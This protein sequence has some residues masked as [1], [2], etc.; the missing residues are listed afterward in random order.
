MR[1][2]EAERPVSWLMMS[3]ETFQEA[4]RFVTSQRARLQESKFKRRHCGATGARKSKW[5]GFSHSSAGSRYFFKVI[6]TWSVR[7]AVGVE[8]PPV[9]LHLEL[10]SFFF[11]YI[12]AVICCTSCLSKLGTTKTNINQDDR[13]IVLTKGQLWLSYSLLFFVLF[14][15]SFC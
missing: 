4:K 7:L 1:L 13:L 11:L 8:D 3:F 12:Y 15:C 14:C 10:L 5:F 9:S 2:S 6:T